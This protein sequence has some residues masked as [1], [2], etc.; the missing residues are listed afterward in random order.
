MYPRQGMKGGPRCHFRTGV[1]ADVHGFQSMISSPERSWLRALMIRV[2]REGI[3]RGSYF[4]MVTHDFRFGN[5][6]VS[7][8]VEWPS[9]TSSG[10]HIQLTTEGDLRQKWLYIPVVRRCSHSL[11]SHFS[12]HELADISLVLDEVEAHV[13]GPTNYAPG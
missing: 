10:V 11:K 9:R 6:T 12:H 8:V 5:F 3:P 7:N 4:A 1:T 2:D 13:V